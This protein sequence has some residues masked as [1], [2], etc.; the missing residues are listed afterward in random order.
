MRLD[1][2][3]TVYY[4]TCDHGEEWLEFVYLHTFERTRAGVLSE[5]EVQSLEDALLVNPRAGDVVAGTGGVRKVRVAQQG[6]GKSGSARVIYLY[7]AEQ[8]TVY[9]VLA[10]PKNVQGNLTAVQ[11][12]AVRALVQEIRDEPWPRRRE[13]A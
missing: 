6:R 5:A 11:T 8:S 13:Q 12:R 7:V 9:L 2:R 10:Y 1:H 3:G 4:S